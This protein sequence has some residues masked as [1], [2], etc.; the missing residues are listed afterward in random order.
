MALLRGCRCRNLLAVEY[1]LLGRDRLLRD[2]APLIDYLLVSGPSEL[3]EIET[4]FPELRSASIR[5]VPHPVELSAIDVPNVNP[6]EEGK[7]LR[8]FFVGGRIESRKNQN[9]VLRI[10]AHVLD[11]EFVFAGQLNETDPTYCAEFRRLL[12]LA[13]N[14]R[15]LGQLSMAA[16]LQHIAYADAVINPSW[17]EVMSLINLYAY[18]LGTPIISALHTFESDLLRDGVIRYDPE[19]PH[20]LEHAL[21]GVGPRVKP[22]TATSSGRIA[23][24]SALTWA[25]FDEFSRCAGERLAGAD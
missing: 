10:A 16:L 3:A 9:A 2:L 23:E 15:W 1:L 8:H 13:P 21:I 19:L 25:G 20:A 4:E 7:W 22:T 24:F 5:I 11:A 18:T 14:C 6:Y 17:F 12:S